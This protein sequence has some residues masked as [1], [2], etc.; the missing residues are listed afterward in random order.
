M[1][2]SKKS[3]KLLKSVKVACLPQNATETVR[4]LETCKIDGFFEKNGFSEKKP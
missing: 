2:F 4:F 1:G 3:W